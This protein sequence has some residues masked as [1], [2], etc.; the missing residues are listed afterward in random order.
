MDEY[1]GLSG[2]EK[3]VNELAKKY[4]NKDAETLTF[5]QAGCG[6]GKSYIVNMLLNA[7]SNDKIRVFL[8]Y[9]DEFRAVDSHSVMQKTNAIGFSGGIFGISIGLSYGWRNPT[10]QYEKIRS[11]LASKLEKDILICVDSMEDISDELKYL[12]FQIIK[13]IQRLERDYHKKIFVLITATQ[14]IYEETILKY[15]VST[16][17]IRLQ[18]Y[19]IN[20]IEEF[21]KIQKKLLRVDVTK[22]YDLCHGNLNLAD[23]LYEE[24]VVQNNNYLDT[25]NDIVN[26]RIA[27]IKRQGMQKELS[28]KDVEDIIFSASLA[29]KKFTAQ[30][31]QGIIEKNV[32][33]ITDGLNI[34]CNEDLLKKDIK[35]LYGFI[36]EEIQEYIAQKT[37]QE[38]EDLFI[39][40]YNYYTENETDEYYTRGHYIYKYH[41]FISDLAE[42]LF[43]LA[44][45]FARKIYDESKV[46]KIENIFFSSHIDANKTTRFKK[47]K[48]FYDDIYD[49]L[50]VSTVIINY[51]ELQNEY[52]DIVVLAEISCECYE[53]LYRK[54]PMTS[55]ESNHILNKCIEYA[56]NELILANSEIEGLVRVDE[57]ILRLKIIY[58]IA[59]CV[60]DQK[61][62]YELFQELYDLSK[63]L[64]VGPKNNKQKSIG[65]Y[66]ENVFNR[67]AFLFVNQAVCDN[68]YEKAKKYF[69]RNEIWIEYYITLACQA[70]T[71]IVIQQFERSIHIC[72]KVKKE[73]AERDI[74]LPQI[75]KLKNNEIIAEFLLK[76]KLAKSMVKAKSAAKEALMKLKKL[77]NQDANATQ[78]VVYTNI[79]SLCLYIGNQIQYTKFKNKLEKLYGCDNIADVNDES[80]DDFYRYYFAWFELYR[81]ISDENWEKAEAI[82][83]SLENFIPAIFRKQEVFWTAKIVAVKTLIANK[84]K[85]DAYDFCTNLVQTKRQEQILSKFFYRGLMVSDIQY[86][87]Y[88]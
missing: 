54:T 40:Y 28:S 29:I 31:L 9:E 16:K 51:D 77:V 17:T 78:F 84:E 80:I 32:S 72:E 38:R 13:N 4:S 86:T 83:D 69:F 87:S 20:D 2:R 33:S 52:M 64:T 37:A 63:E 58:S 24:I 26:K 43:L 18:K 12:I 65:E 6:Q 56:K 73:C 5:I 66:I 81:E 57:T 55:L 74:Q 68:Y 59:P 15:N 76:E 39:S 25:L 44:Y 45:S 22:I 71:Y 21:F 27:V 10:S 88:F 41:G 3:L 50:D 75:E 62:N 11:M 67:K 8:N 30:F 34:A 82:A 23:F 79:C 35:K 14:D 60:L 85:K 46:K 47:V 53:Y 70:G 49:E 19:E 36:S 42:S 1:K 48:K 7:L 61:N